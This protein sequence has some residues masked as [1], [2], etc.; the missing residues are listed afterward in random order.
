MRNVK[1]WSYVLGLLLLLA[2]PGLYVMVAANKTIE[3]AVDSAKKAFFK[4]SVEIHCPSGVTEGIMIPAGRGDLCDFND[5]IVIG[6]RWCLADVRG[7]SIYKLANNCTV[8][9]KYPEK[10]I[11]PK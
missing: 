5:A 7:R 6:N 8:V 9:R 2:V 3:V 4:V 11:I 1:P 10:G